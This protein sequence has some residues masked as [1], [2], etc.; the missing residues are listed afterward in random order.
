MEKTKE[1]LKFP[2]CRCGQLLLRNS[3]NSDWE[4]CKLDGKTCDAIQWNEESHI[5]NIIHPKKCKEHKIAGEQACQ[6]Y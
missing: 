5:Y 2:Y 4:V 6:E 1:E 3:Y